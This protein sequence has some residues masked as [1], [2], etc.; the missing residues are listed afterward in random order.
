[1]S[2]SYRFSLK[3]TAILRDIMSSNVGDSCS[4]I[5]REDG[6]DQIKWLSQTETN[7]TLNHSYLTTI[8]RWELVVS[9]K[10]FKFLNYLS[11]ISKKICSNYTPENQM[12]IEEMKCK[13]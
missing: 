11:K 5:T 1:M 4:A 2:E 6:V 8:E 7:S 10:I 9:T 12:P 3:A 13:K